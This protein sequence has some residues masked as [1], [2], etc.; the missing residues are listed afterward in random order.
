MKQ[1]RVA[2]Q[3]FVSAHTIPDSMTPAVSLTRAGLPRIIP[4]FHRRRISQGDLLTIQMYMSLF[5]LSKLIPLAPRVSKKTFES[6][7]T[8]LVQTIS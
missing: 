3:K 1:S 2:L 8:M 6:I 4:A 5:S 7:I